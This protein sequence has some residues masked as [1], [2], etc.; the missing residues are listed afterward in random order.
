MSSSDV[1]LE[2]VQRTL[3]EISENSLHVK[4]WQLYNL[5]K[6]RTAAIASG[7]YPEE[8]DQII[9]KLH[10]E[11]IIPFY[12]E[13]GPYKEYAIIGRLN[14]YLLEEKNRRKFTWAQR[15]RTCLG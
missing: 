12:S 9:S 8:A 10:H 6:N 11:N 5:W 2:N 7:N 14:Y 1:N 4:I 13:N 15:R 3:E